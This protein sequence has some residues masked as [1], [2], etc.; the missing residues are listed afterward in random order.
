M[1]IAHYVDSF[2]ILSETFIYDYIIELEE[3]GTNNIVVTQ[4]IVNREDR[5]FEKVIKVKT[6]K[7]WDIERLLHRIQ[8]TFNGSDPITSSW[9][10]IQRKLVKIIKSNKPDIIHAHFGPMGILISPIAKKFNIPLIV[11]FYGYDVSILKQKK[12]WRKRYSKLW[13]QVNAVT[14]LSNAMKKD[15]IDM[16]CPESKIHIIHLSRKLVNSRAKQTISS[17]NKFITIGRLTEK[18]GHLHSIKA[19]QKLKE[20]GIKLNLEIIGDGELKNHL[21]EYVK[22]N[23]LSDEIKFLGALSSEKTFE[24][25]READA[26]ILSSKT[27]ENGDRE[28]TPTVL[29]EAQATGLP[30]IATRHSGIPEMFPP[31][32]QWMLATEGDVDEI[33]FKISE[34]LKMSEKEIELIIRRGKE[35][36]LKEFNLSTE[37]KNLLELYNKERLNR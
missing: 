11:T 4:N 33:A 8:T 9:P 36:I 20:I 15:V 29:V 35:F 13:K 19:F 34:L 27:A 23:N 37:V 22:E 17:I 25:L 16:G 30:C 28:G 5:P 7:K 32:N 26:F 10:Q 12:Y 21:E 31:E 3:Q 14:V 2:S 24:K 6:P 18:K 1:K